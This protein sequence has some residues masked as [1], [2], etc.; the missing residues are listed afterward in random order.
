MCLYNESPWYKLKLPGLC[1]STKID[2]GSNEGPS[3][4]VVLQR[5]ILVQMTAPVSM[6]L[7]KESNW[8][9]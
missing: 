1:S 3:A 8:Y 5:I 9:N 4:S 6:W 7:Y 2:T